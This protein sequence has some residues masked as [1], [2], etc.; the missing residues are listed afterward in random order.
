MLD[1]PLP[2][3]GTRTNFPDPSSSG[4][5]VQDLSVTYP[6][7]TDP[8]LDGVSLTVAPGEILALVGPQR[9]RQVDAPRA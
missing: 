5:E 3:R 9:M 2:P 8:A 6:G 1:A 4:L 7:R